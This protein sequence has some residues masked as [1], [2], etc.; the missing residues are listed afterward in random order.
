MM[1]PLFPLNFD[2][3]IYQIFQLLLSLIQLA[4]T[5]AA[6]LINWGPIFSRLSLAVVDQ[7]RYGKLMTNL[8]PI[9]E[10]VL[11]PCIFHQSL[12]VLL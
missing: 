11:P 1:N 8:Y 3:H 2:C 6:V 5:S 12:L 9:L 4:F 7:L 10:L